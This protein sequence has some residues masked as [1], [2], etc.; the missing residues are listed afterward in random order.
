M[1]YWWGLN[2]L[3]TKSMTLRRLSHK[4]HW[5]FMDTIVNPSVW[6]IGRAKELKVDDVGISSWRTSGRCRA[7]GWKDVWSKKRTTAWTHACSMQ[8]SRE[9]GQST[10][11]LRDM[12]M[13]VVDVI[14]H[15]IK[16]ETSVICNECLVWCNDH[17][18]VSGNQVASFRI[19]E[20]PCEFLSY[21]SIIQYI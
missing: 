17:K 4:R 20:H 13:I 19:L 12:T 6:S 15:D 1:S 18:F 16:R 9:E 2:W 7:S 14:N 8:K 21:A 10:G 11:W 3:R 5:R